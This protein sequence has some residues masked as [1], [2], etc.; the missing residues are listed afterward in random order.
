MQPSSINA[1]L[2]S[3]YE[4]DFSTQVRDKLLYSPT[5]VIR[6]FINS[7]NQQPLKKIKF[8]IPNSKQ[9]ASVSPNCIINLV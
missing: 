1:I 2:C 7:K 6:I 3:S 5:G 9:V 4:G 8:G